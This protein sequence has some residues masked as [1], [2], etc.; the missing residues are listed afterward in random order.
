[1]CADAYFRGMN[2]RVVWLMAGLGFSIL[3][4]S[5]ATATKFAL[6][7]AQPLIIAVVRFGIASLIMITT[8]HLVLRQRLPERRQWRALTIY[9]LLNITIYL[10]LYVIAMQ[11]ITAGIAALAIA[12]NP[13][14]I[15]FISFLVLR[16]KL[17]RNVII[18]I[19]ICVAGVLCAS[20]PLLHDAVVTPKGLIILLVSMLSYS[21]G[22]IYFS[23][24]KWNDLQLF[25]INGWQ[26]G[27]GGLLLL[28]FALL[29]YHGASTHFD[30]R[31]WWST[32]WLAV[33]VSIGAVQLWLWLLKANA[34]AAS[35][36]LFL[37]PL[38]GFLISGWLMKEQITAYTIAGILLVIGGLL[39]AQRNLKKTTRPQQAAEP[40]LEEG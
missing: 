40:I 3:W 34:V 36:W 29:E 12:T 32:L 35:L 11:Y 38:F 8:S 20:W 26:T 21:L 25:T 16:K 15:S 10:G 2:A 19:A 30:A 17:T 24:S 27:I 18:S 31:F 13:V 6:H 22:A 14:F 5:A 39:L 9:G 23:A 33:P 28:P 37:C 4:A 7:S 1:M